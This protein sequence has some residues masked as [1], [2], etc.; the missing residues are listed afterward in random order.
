MKK[1]VTLMIVAG[2]TSA[3]SAAE[4]HSVPYAS[5]LYQDTEWTVVDVNKDGKTWADNSSSYNYSGSRFTSGK[6]YS[7]HSSNDGN[8]WLISP[9]VT[10]EAG[11]EYKAKYWVN[12]R[13]Y[14][15]SKKLTFADSGDV[16]AL[17]A[18]TV[19]TDFTATKAYPSMTKVSAVFTV[20]TTGTY[21]FGFLAYSPKNMGW[22]NLTGFEVCENVFTPAAVSKLTCTAG[23]DYALEAT[24]GWELPTT[25]ND[26]VA[27]PDDAVFNNIIIKR[28]GAEVA[29][30]AGDATIWTDTGSTGLTP[31]YHTYEVAVV[32][33][34]AQSA[35]TTVASKYIGPIEAQSMPYDA[36]IN[37]L[38]QDDF[39]LFWTPVKGRASTSTDNWK[40]AVSTYYGNSIQYYGGSGKVQDD[41]I[42]S[43][44]M[45]FEQPGVYKLSVTLSYSTYSSTDFDIL[46]GSGN[47][48]G[49]Y[50][51]VIRNFKT[52]PTADTDYEIFFTV[53]TPGEYGIAFHAHAETGSYS[54]YTLRKFVVE[55]WRLTPTHVADLTVTVSDDAT[56]VTLNWT[57]PTTT[58][59]GEEL[60]DLSKVELYAD[61]ELLETFSN[62]TPGAVMNH[63]YVPATPGVHEYYVLPYSSEGAADG[64]PVKVKSA[65]VGDETQTLPYASTFS[66][67]DATTPLWRGFNANGDVAE[68]V[69]KST[70]AALS[71]SK[72]QD[73]YK[74]DDYLLSPY[75][76]LT[77]GYYSA[78]YSI[79]GAGKNVKLE[80]GLTADKKN[81][82]ATF[83]PSGTVTLPGQS[84]TTDYT[85][86]IHV[87]AEGRYAFTLRNNIIASTDDYDL[88]VTKVQ[89][90]YQPVAPSVATDLTVIPAADLSNSATITWT[91]PT[92]TNI[93]GVTPELVK[94]VITR[95]GEEIGEVTEGLTPG[96]TSSYE[97]TTVP[98]AGE[99]T[100]TVTIHGPEG[101]S[102]DKP[103]E[104]KSPWIGAGLDL[105]FD[106]A[107]SFRDAGWNIYNVNNDSN[108]WGGDNLGGKQ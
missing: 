86:L 104:V 53:D 28:D 63:D 43:P 98:E 14:T 35:F 90:A 42:I 100:Y 8:D 41:W 57:N 108:S 46:I 20:P 17:A 48:I 61:G 4:P 77:P 62:L 9:A 94:A 19:L 3:L 106:C 78:T 36:N 60:T 87:T 38:T 66:A 37:T 76:I 75:F 40:L 58:N 23:E 70:G 95:D 56:T 50:E 79:K 2:L 34:G 88:V 10:L 29:T 52:I 105:P 44:Q 16:D 91:N 59:T 1:I 54:T 82:A 7:Y 33:N 68:W 11:K 13:S 25:D 85:V 55:K 99:Y 32:V 26:G 24:L 51:T 97:D 45:K 103:A 65:W 71:V 101:A 107:D 81:V 83:T 15:E 47:S 6:Q 22:I 64:E 12:T 80:I 18:G 73:Y 49:G 67:D 96:E 69:I 92:T 102:A 93:E 5:G 31:G 72:S 39:D 21:Y 84:W 30:I 89:F 27:L 74:N